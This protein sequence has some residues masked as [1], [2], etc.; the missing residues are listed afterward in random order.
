MNKTFV[1]TG[2][3]A[4]DLTWEGH[5]VWWPFFFISSFLRRNSNIKQFYF[6]L[7]G[8]FTCCMSPWGL[9]T[10]PFL[11]LSVNNN[12]LRACTCIPR[13]PSW[14]ISK[15]CTLQ[16]LLLHNYWINLSDLF[17]KNYFFQIK[18]I[19]QSIFLFSC[20]RT[21][22]T[23]LLWCTLLYSLWLAFTLTLYLRAAQN[24][25]KAAVVVENSPLKPKYVGGGGWQHAVTNWEE[26]WKLLILHVE[27]WW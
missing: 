13:P 23:E 4:D 17:F 27:C 14:F 10:L 20:K 11:S 8:S 2:L 26:R 9:P 5:E 18:N 19:E 1:E 22:L 12:G 7:L 24:L 21:T 25:D 15:T 16:W 6:Q 3:F